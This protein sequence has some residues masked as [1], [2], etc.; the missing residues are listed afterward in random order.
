M[1][2]KKI[3][4]PRKGIFGLQ[5]MEKVG[6]RVVS[7]ERKCQKLGRREGS[8]KKKQ[9]LRMLYRMWTLGG[10]Q[11]E[12]D[13]ASRFQGQTAQKGGPSGNHGFLFFG[14]SGKFSKGSHG[15]CRAM[16]APFQFKLEMSIM[17]VCLCFQGR[18]TSCF[19]SGSRKQSLQALKR[20]FLLKENSLLKI[21]FY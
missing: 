11:N 16:P 2:S 14:A 10:A 20:T 17:L 12:E 6:Y 7:K 21:R 13:K 5:A 9:Q 19:E 1:Y 18:G 3:E 15:L 8:Q 4:M